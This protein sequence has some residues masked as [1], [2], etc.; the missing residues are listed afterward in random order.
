MQAGLYKSFAVL[1][2]LA[3]Y[4]GI[5]RTQLEEF[6][7]TEGMLMYTWPLWGVKLL[8]V[9][10]SEN[11]G[12]CKSG[13]LRVELIGTRVVLGIGASAALIS[14][15]FRKQWFLSVILPDPSTL[16]QYW[17]DSDDFSSSV[18]P[19][20]EWT[21]DSYSVTS[22]SWAK[23]IGVSVIPFYYFGIL[24]VEDFLMCRQYGEEISETFL[25]NLKEVWVAYFAEVS[26]TKY[27]R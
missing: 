12:G 9:S 24:V 5:T 7:M 20:T 27:S 4:V 19:V 18:L 1:W 2:G 10:L 21:L 13:V 16:F 26:I 14:H 6:S 11:V 15:F 3:C 23:V 17:K 25:F 8:C 22:S